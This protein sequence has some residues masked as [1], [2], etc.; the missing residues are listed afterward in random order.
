VRF[1]SWSGLMLVLVSA[2]PIALQIAEIAASNVVYARYFPVEVAKTSVTL[3]GHRINVTDQAL[4]IDGR[5]VQ[6]LEGA[7]SLAVIDLRDRRSGTSLPIIVEWRGG[8]EK[9]TWRYQTV[10]VHPRSRVTIDQFSYMERASPRLRTVLARFVSPY[11]IGFFSGAQ[12]WPTLL[13]P[14]IFPWLTAFC[15]L[16]ISFVSLFAAWRQRTQSR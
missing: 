16:V 4:I 12:G 9:S 11:M 10:A 14:I 8:E 13:Y 7:Q 6:R 15:G 2:Y 1:V 3:R 5:R